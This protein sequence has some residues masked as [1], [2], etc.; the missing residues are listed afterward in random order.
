MIETRKLI[1]RRL[2][3]TI[4][5]GE[6]NEQQGEGKKADAPSQQ[7]FVWSWELAGASR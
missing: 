6:E 4:E 7:R 5:A 1:K 2:R 3:C